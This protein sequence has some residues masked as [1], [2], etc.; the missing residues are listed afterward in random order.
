MS[1]AVNP[2]AVNELVNELS[3]N[4][5]VNPESIKPEM[6]NSLARW[7]VVHTYSGYE[8]K[9]KTNIEKLVENR[10]MQNQILEVLVP[11]IDDMA[12]LLFLKDHCST[13]K[14]MMSTLGC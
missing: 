11:L 9:V 10:G 1:D 14:A 5:I 6:T 2:D 12:D 13:E 8:N 7:Y 4:E 3:E